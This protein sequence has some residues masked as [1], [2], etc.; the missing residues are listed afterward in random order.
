M[1]KVQ[2]TRS[3]LCLWLKRSFKTCKS[4]YA[5][6]ESLMF[7]REKS[8]LRSQGQNVCMIGKYNWK[9]LNSWQK[10]AKYTSPDSSKSNSHDNAF[11]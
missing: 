1:V 4:T 6:Y 2:V 9:G 11:C 5:K 10:H 8:R 7:K 3:T